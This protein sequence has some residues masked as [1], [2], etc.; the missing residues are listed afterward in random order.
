MV[1]EPRTTIVVPVRNRLTLTQ[2][3]VEALVADYGG[4][5]EVELVVVDDGST[6]GTREYL[7]GADVRIV[8]HSESR[9]S[10]HPATTEPAP[11]RA[12]SWFPEQRHSGGE[13]SWLDALV[14]YAEA[15]PD[16]AVVG[17]RLLYQNATIQHAGIVFGGRHAPATRLPHVPE[18]ASRSR[19]SSPIQAVTAACMLVRR[20]C[21][22]R[23]EA[24]TQASQMVS[25]M[26]T[27][28]FGLR[29]P[30][31]GRTTAR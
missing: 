28:A 29:R 13:G 5:S 21:S 18:R 11:A 4:R 20:R 8:T 27:S 3:C 19:E 24:S 7:E 17:A 22:R 16:A 31:V 2:P 23:S 26:S 10:R 15:T 14:S 1:D 25:T 12:S 9:A 6:D 30:G